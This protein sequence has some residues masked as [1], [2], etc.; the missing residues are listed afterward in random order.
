MANPF[1]SFESFGGQAP[2]DEPTADTQVASVESG[3]R[4]ESV[5]EQYEREAC[6]VVCEQ[7]RSE[8]QQELSGELSVEK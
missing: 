8:L 4:P 2:E 6:K 7:F 5:V 3:Q 1:E